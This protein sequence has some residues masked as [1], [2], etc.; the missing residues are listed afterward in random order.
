MGEE[1][2]P[3]Q[4]I[5]ETIRENAGHVLVRR[6]VTVDSLCTALTALLEAPAEEPNDE[7]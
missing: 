3:E 2:T 7:S 6:G 5:I 1:L 4:E